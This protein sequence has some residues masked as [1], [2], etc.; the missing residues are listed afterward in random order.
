M[1]DKNELIIQRKKLLNNF[2]DYFSEEREVM[3]VFLG[4]SLASGNPDAFSDIDFRVLVDD[5]VNK[6][7]FLTNFITRTEKIAFIETQSE[8]YAVLHFKNFIKLDIFIYYQQE[9]TAT[10]W[11]KEIKIFKDDGFLKDLK[12]NSKDK[13]FQLKQKEFD[14][15]LNKFYAW[16]H[17]LYRRQQRKEKNYSELCTLMLKNIL[18]AFWY[19]EKGICPNSI[20]D[21]SKIEG[22][23]SNSKLTDKEQQFLSKNTPVIDISKFMLTISKMLLDTISKIEQEYPIKFDK[24]KFNQLIE[25]V[26]Y[27]SMKRR[28][29]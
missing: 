29:E 11:M 6:E 24:K 16:Y 10:V 23:H 27:Q 4:G 28:D 15:Y 2:I 21:W 19:F 9:L 8:N 26:S 3:G 5:K 22:L 1:F 13:K 25:I 7:K 17:E 18:S 14:E 12:E 20:G